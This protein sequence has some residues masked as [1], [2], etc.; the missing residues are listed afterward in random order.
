MHDISDKNITLTPLDLISSLGIFDLDPCAA[1][2]HI[3]AKEHILLPRD[4]LK[5]EWNGRTWL[6]PPYNNPIPWLKKLSEHNNGIALVLA[7]MEVGWMH[8]YVFPKANSILFLRGRP[9]FMRLDKTSVSIMR[10]T[11]LVAYGPENSFAL[12]NSGLKG[13]FIPLK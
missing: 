5:E 3:T 7:S 12:Q 2:Y 6:N 1:P 4:G 10:G 11:V 8:D 13:K 9:K